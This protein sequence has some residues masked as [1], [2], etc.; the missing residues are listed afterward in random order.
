ML[1]A[2]RDLRSVAGSVSRGTIARIA[3]VIPP[4]GPA[5]VAEATLRTLIVRG[6]CRITTDAE[7]ALHA[8]LLLAATLPDDDVDAFAAATAV[9]LAD[10][11]QR[12]RGEDDL[13]WHWD[14]F[15]PH[16]RLLEPH[17]RAAIFQGYAHAHRSG[18]VTLDA[19]PGPAD[20]VTRAPMDVR[21]L[22]AGGG[23]GRRTVMLRAAV[24]PGGEDAP[25]A[26]LWES[27][28]ARLRR[29]PSAAPLLAA[30]RHLY[31]RSPRWRPFGDRLFDPADPI[32]PFLPQDRTPLPQEIP[33]GPVG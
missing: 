32:V 6:R 2:I 22:L 1:Q 18:L 4:D 11:L 31:E 24:E 14:A 12:G 25:A 19:L 7:M 29:D 3:A 20:L 5:S 9:L 27:E 16:Y 21:A 10:R 30:L 26:E 33:S 13:Y 15:Q 8:H 23:E 28:G 17:V